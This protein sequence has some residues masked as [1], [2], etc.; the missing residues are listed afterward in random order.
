MAS[1]PA[2]PAWILALWLVTASRRLGR[3]LLVFLALFLACAIP[4]ATSLASLG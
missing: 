4:L 2:G 1:P 3:A